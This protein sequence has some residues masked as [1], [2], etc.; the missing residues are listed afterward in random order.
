M[1]TSEFELSAESVSAS[2]ARRTTRRILRGFGLVL[3]QDLEDTV[4]LL[5]SELTTN[6]IRH[7]TGATFMVSLQIGKELLRVAVIDRANGSPQLRTA[8]ET[9]QNGRG[10]ELVKALSTRFGWN[11]LGDGNEVWFE[12]EFNEPT[13]PT[14]PV[15][16]LAGER[17]GFQ[18]AM[19]GSATVVVGG[20]H[21]LATSSSSLGASGTE[22][23]DARGAL[24]KA[25]GAGAV[26]GIA[27]P[28][29]CSFSPLHPLPCPWTTP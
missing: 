27:V 6:A 10:L 13:Q 26:R 20:A 17:G 28:D 3:G 2:T 19:P 23:R 21:T 8:A 24:V 11:R 7:A 5:V 9:D 1:P 12:L 29:R 15:P 4:L 22:G 14:A 18:I 16:A 25:G